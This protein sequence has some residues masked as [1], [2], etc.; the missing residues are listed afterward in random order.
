MHPHPFLSWAGP[1]GVENL[2]TLV[3]AVIWSRAA[4]D[5]SK[6]I[7]GSFVGASW[8]LL[9]CGGSQVM[10][11]ACLHLRWVA[12][13][14]RVKHQ[15]HWPAQPLPA[16]LQKYDFSVLSEQEA[17]RDVISSGSGWSSQREALPSVLWAAP[18]TPPSLS[19]TAGWARV[20]PCCA[21]QSWNDLD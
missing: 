21:L 8:Q 10:V 19:T 6:S 5:S 1:T 13:D 12:T 7:Y 18:A 4:G 2:L 11:W 17:Y 15:C 9:T 20:G 3:A 14:C 16:A